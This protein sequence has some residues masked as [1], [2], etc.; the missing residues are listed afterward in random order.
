VVT[1]AACA[2]EGLAELVGR[3]LEDLSLAGAGLALIGELLTL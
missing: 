2:G 1:W 3:E